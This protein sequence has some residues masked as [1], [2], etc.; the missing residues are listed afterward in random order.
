MSFL[1]KPKAP[2][3]KPPTVMPDAEDPS[4]RAAGQKQMSGMQAQ[5]GRASTMLSGFG[6]GDNYGQN[7]MGGTG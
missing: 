2:K 4:V 3:E 6:L 7:R 5:S 1:K